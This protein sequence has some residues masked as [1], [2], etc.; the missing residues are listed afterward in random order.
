MFLIFILLSIYCFHTTALNAQTQKEERVFMIADQM[1]RPSEGLAGFRTYIINN[2]QRPQNVM[3]GT[4]VFVQFIVE[5]DGSLSNFRIINPRVSEEA[6]RAAIQV[7]E[8]YPNN[9]LPGLVRGRSARVRQAVA[10]PF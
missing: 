4:K 7:L 3:P 1:P 8:N 2:L 9:W 6:S 5:K 10:V